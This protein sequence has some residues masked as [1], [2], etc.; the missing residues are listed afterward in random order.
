MN[1]FFLDIQFNNANTCS[2]SGIIEFCPIAA[3]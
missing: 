3:V 1:A 2:L